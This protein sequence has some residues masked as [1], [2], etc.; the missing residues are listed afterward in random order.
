MINAVNSNNLYVNVQQYNL[1][2][3]SIQNTNSIWSGTSNQVNLGNPFDV[4]NVVNTGNA[5]NMGSLVNTNMDWYSSFSM[6]STGIITQV[7][8]Q[9]AEAAAK[10]AAAEAAAAAAAAAAVLLAQQKAAAAQA[11]A[12]SADPY[13]VN[14]D[15]K[16]YIF[17]R[18]TNGNNK[19]DGKQ[20]ILGINDTKDNLFADM[21]SLDTNKDGKV[22]TD[23]LAAA[24][25]SLNE[26]LDG[27]ISNRKYDLNKINGV[28]LSS[29]TAI[30]NTNSTGTFGTFT[31]GLKNG[32]TA[33]GKE[34]FEDQDYFNKLLA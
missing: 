18:D 10:K 5:F 13:E 15:G 29:L 8:Q 25:V 32:S 22:S 26:V 12:A 6:I 11:A 3:N 28:D 23:E 33:R 21:K 27:K 20:E 14:I 30:D 4:G 2:V 17:T 16:N 19:V 24:G 1:N 9:A 34:T 7:N 31:L